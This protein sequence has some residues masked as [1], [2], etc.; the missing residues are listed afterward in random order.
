MAESVGKGLVRAV[1][2]ARE[3]RL[4]RA[5]NGVSYGVYGD[6][7]F[8]DS[9]FERLV[10]AVPSGIADTLAQKEFFFVPLAMNAGRR[11]GDADALIAET[12]TEELADDAICHRNVSL[13]AR[14]GVFLSTRLLGDKFAVAFE[15]FINVGHGF[16]EAAGVPEGFGQLC[17]AQALKDV[18]GETSQDAWE[19]RQQALAA[20]G[21]VDEKAKAEYLDAAFADSLAIYLLS[22]AVDFDYSELREREYPLLAPV[23]LADR[24]RWVAKQFPPNSS[25]EF[26]IKY[27]RRA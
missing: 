15:L 11:G 5:P 24:L 12:Y 20:K 14:E 23:A 3:V 21:K 18:K 8:P 7:A 16:V 4:E 10:Q 22:L 1:D 13:G 17:W 2:V 6:P 9:E 25:Y 26:A 27:R 19:S